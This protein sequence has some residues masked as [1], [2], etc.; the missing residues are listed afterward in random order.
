MRDEDEIEEQ[1]AWCRKHNG[2]PTNRWP[3]LT[4][5]QGVESAL[6]WVLESD[7]EPPIES[8][9]DADE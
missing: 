8:D 4:Y 2:A 7:D 6:N 9:P 3:G 5:E 1:I